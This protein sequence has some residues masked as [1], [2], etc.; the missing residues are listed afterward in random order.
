MSPSMGGSPS[1]RGASP[2]VSQPQFDEL[3]ARIET[4][5]KHLGLDQPAKQLAMESGPAA[6]VAEQPTARLLDNSG[7]SMTLIGKSFVGIALA[8]LLRALTESNLLPHAAGVGLGLAYALAWLMWAARTDA[9]QTV[10]ISL[11]ALTSALVL[12]PLLWEATLRF[13]AL[14]SAVTAALLVFFCAFGLVISWRK[15]LTSVAWVTSLAGLAAC[16]VLIFQ[17]KDLLPYTIALV[18]IAAAVEISACMEHYLGERWIVALMADL[19]V[20][21]MLAVATR[22]NDAGPYVPMNRWAIFAVQVALLATYLG[23]TFIRTLARARDI[24]DFEI[25]QC[26]ASFLIASA[27]ALRLAGGDPAA[28]KAVGAICAIAGASCYVVSFA[29]KARQEGRNR[30][31]QTYATFALAL[32]LGGSWLLLQGAVVVSAWTALAV[33]FAVAGTRAGRLTL[34]FHAAAY[35]LLAML[36]SGAALATAQRYLTTASHSPHTLPPPSLWI[37][38]AGALLGYFVVTARS[39]AGPPS[40]VAVPLVMGSSAIWSLAGILAA[41]SEVVC[42]NA[43]ADNQSPDLCATLLTCVLAAVCLASAYQARRLRRR[44]LQWIAVVIA[45]IAAYKLVIQDLSHAPAFG[46]VVSLLAYGGTL[47]LLPRLSRWSRSEA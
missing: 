43:T 6:E 20:L 37:V 41:V 27:G 13:H 40:G 42:R 7:D 44:E 25:G 4:I 2:G 31:F 28:V 21:L 5:E 33:C 16:A 23:S 17:S 18:A 12:V 9:A 38:T 10:T 3:V 32:V 15:N 34:Q 24:T 22:G 47:S 39:S 1:P 26:V 14:S 19:S 29:F 35:L 8:Y 36:V 45:V 11:R 46:V 30:N